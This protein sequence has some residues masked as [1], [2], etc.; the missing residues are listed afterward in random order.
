MRGAAETYCLFLV[1]NR[2]QIPTVRKTPI[3]DPNSVTYA[4]KYDQSEVR[5]SFTTTVINVW[6]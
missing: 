3:S 5:N 6:R 1:P 2:H 4:L